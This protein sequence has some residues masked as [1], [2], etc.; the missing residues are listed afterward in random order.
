M[1]AG[2]AVLI[3][4]LV[5]GYCGTSSTSTT[6]IAT[7]HQDAAALATGP[8]DAI[9]APQPLGIGADA[10]A[11]R[12]GTVDAGMKRS[13]AALATVRR[14]ASVSLTPTPTPAVTADAGVDKVKEARALFDKAHAAIEEGEI[15]EALQL[16]EQSLKLRRTARTLLEKA[17]VLHLQGRTDAALATV[18][19]AIKQNTTYA[20][21]YDQKAM[22][23]RSAKRFDEA[24]PLLEKYLELQPNGARSEIIRGML[25]ADR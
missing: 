22:I 1:L 7:T 11:K 23:L 3:G 25:D 12:H 21:A 24:R 19:E 20:P 15:D 2:S 17:R 10:A 14:D 18:N 16:L 13:D 6:P 8:S 5:V 4:V 9:A